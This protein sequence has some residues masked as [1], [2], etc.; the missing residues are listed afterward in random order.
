M[1]PGQGSQLFAIV[2]LLLLIVGVLAFVLPMRGTVA[3]L[4]VT[5]AAKADELQAL[6]SEL[7]ALST[8][9]SQVAESE[10]TKQALLAAV[11]VGYSQDE[12][13][14]E[15]SQMAQDSNFSLNAM[16]FSQSVDENF[17]NT[18]SITA[19]FSGSYDDLINFLQKLETA[20]RL[21]RVT[22]L[23]VQLTS[24]STVTFNLG[25]EAYYQ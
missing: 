23:N 8:L 9:A 12:L 15:L 24:T 10:T 3:E 4:E 25:L 5:K 22:S 11:P 19:N 13:I 2:L 6:Q 21:I 1:K 17:G 14:L 7:D 18:L 16:N 20:E